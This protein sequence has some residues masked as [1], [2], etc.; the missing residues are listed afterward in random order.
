MA[1]FRSYPLPSAWV[2][3][4]SSRIFK[5]LHSSHLYL[6][7][8][9]LYSKSALISSASRLLCSA[10]AFH[11]CACAF[12]KERRASGVAPAVSLVLRLAPSV[13]V[14]G[15]EASA[16]GAVVGAWVF[17]VGVFIV[18]VLL[19]SDL[20]FSGCCLGDCLPLARLLVGL[21]TF[22]RLLGGLGCLLAEI[23]AHL[24]IASRSC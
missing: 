6:Y 22:A 23:L 2:L 12:Q 19:L 9:R 11:S 14:A 18:W 17:I 3:A 16:V 1:L 21:E 13:W 24:G 7:S 4:V 5:V 15:V 8:S 10:S 20:H